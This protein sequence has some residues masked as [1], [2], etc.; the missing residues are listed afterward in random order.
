MVLIAIAGAWREPTHLAE[1]RLTRQA[2]AVRSID[3]DGTVVIILKVREVCVICRSNLL[4]VSF[5]SLS[6]RK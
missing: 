4:P 5:A 6:T 3:T 2:I 1:G